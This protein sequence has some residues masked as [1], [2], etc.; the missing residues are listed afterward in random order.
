M[1]LSELAGKEIV[2]VDEGARVGVVADVEVV[3]ET[4]TGRV[5][6]LVSPGPSGVSRWASWLGASRSAPFLVPWAAVEKIGPDLV[7]IRQQQI[8]N[9]PPHL[10]N[11]EWA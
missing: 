9:L 8:R 2:A 1:R 6:A 5:E 10:R 11:W 7:V 4:E 3:I